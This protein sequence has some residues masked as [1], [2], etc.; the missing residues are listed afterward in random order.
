MRYSVLLTGTGGEGVLSA[1]K[2]LAQCAASMG[3]ATFVPWYGAAQR[4]GTARCTVVL[5]N[6]EI[7]SPLPGLCNAVIATSDAA[8][9]RAAQEILPSGTLVRNSN[10]S[11]SRIKA[12]GFSVLDTPAD[13]IARESGNVR[14]SSIVLVGAL[15]GSVS[16]VPKMLVM[17][18]LDKA[19]EEKGSEFA[20]SVK[21]AFSAG[22]EWGSDKSR[23]KYLEPKTAV[24]SH[25]STEKTTVGEMLDTPEIR[26]IVEEI[27][28]QVLNHPLIDAG[29]TFR[30]ID[31]VPYMKDMI[32]AEELD[33]FE[34]R[35]EALP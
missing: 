20:A 6:K 11:R 23:L 27:F 1:G 31:A 21:K 34:A 32:T 3:R 4:G 12:G 16:L 5:S 7:L 30:F 28:P 14:N 13:D 35:L 24:S 2:I 22:Y 8:V 17:K 19:L 29:R 26:A 9:Q 25:Y 18:A 15:L 33:E 10:N